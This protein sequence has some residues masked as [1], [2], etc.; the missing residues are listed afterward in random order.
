[1][2]MPFAAVAAIGAALLISGCSSEPAGP[3]AEEVRAT[4]CAGFAELTPGYLET[5]ADQKT[6]SDKGSSLE[7][8]TDAS[9]RIMKRTTDDGRRT[10][11]YDCDARSDKELF[12]EYIS[13]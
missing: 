12:A 5:Q 3:T 13:K 6:V 8:R 2:K 1:M 4:Q 9:M 11:A 7:E 10:H